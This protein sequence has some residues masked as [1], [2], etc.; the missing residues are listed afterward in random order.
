MLRAENL[1]ELKVISAETVNMDEI[2]FATNKEFGDGFK[3]KWYQPTYHFHKQ[4]ICNI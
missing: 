4:T 3:T 2:W 1:D